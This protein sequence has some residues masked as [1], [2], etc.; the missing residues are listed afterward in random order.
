MARGVIRDELVAMYHED[1]YILIKGMLN[2]EETCL[3][4]RSARE[5]RILD[6]HFLWQRRRRRRHDSSLAVEPSDRHNLRHDRS[7]RIHRGHGRET[8]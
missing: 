2:P 6:Q 8:A 1:G 7:L 4:A 5:D 3:L